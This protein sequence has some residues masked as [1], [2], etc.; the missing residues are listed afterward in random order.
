[1]PHAGH[2][3]VGRKRHGHGT[4]HDG[5]ADH[6]ESGD[7]ARQEHHPRQGAHSGVHRHHRIVRDHHRDAHEGLCPGALC[8]VGRLHPADRGELHHPRPRRGLRFEEQC[9]RFGA[10]RH[11][12]R[13][14]LHPV[15]HGH[16]F[17]ARDVG[18]RLDLRL[19]L[20]HLRLHAVDLRAG[21]GCFPGARLPHGSV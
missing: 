12:H 3:H 21:A 11:R 7:F 16:R 1:M 18:Q 9:V 15:A 8:V 19:E 17:G 6:V 20:R 4:G 10:R 13:P 14:G 2:H 5:R